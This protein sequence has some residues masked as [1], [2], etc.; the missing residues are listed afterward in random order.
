MPVVG[1][2]N[3]LQWQVLFPNTLVARQYTCEGVDLYVKS[4]RW[5]FTRYQTED[6]TL[7]SARNDKTTLPT[8]DCISRGTCRELDATVWLIPRCGQDISLNAG[9]GCATTAACLP[10][11]MAARSAGSGRDNLVLASARRWRQGL[12]V[13]GQDCAMSSATPESIGQSMGRTGTV[14]RAEGTRAGLLQGSGVAVH[15]FSYS[16]S[17]AC[18]RAPRMTSIVDKPKGERVAANVGLSGQPFAITGDTGM[19]MVDLGGG[20]V[21]VQVERLEGDE[22]DIF[23][24]NGIN[25]ELPAHPRALVPLQEAD[26]KDTEKLVVPYSYQTARIAAVNTRNYVFYASNPPM[27]VFGAYFEYC[28]GRDDRKRQIK[29][30]LLLKSSYSPIRIYRVSAYRRCAKYSCGNNLVSF[31]TLEGFS[32]NFTRSCDEVPLDDFALFHTDTHTSFIIS[33]SY[34]KLIPHLFIY[35]HRQT[36]SI[37]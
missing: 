25:Q 11:C 24:L 22:A 23:S 29:M 9:E 4:V 13:M 37:Y 36:T 5:S 2:M 7:G 30:G 32:Q 21:S 33:M 1:L 20:A 10:F 35:V 17:V 26:F 8:T 34:H 12:T 19:T 3:L 31:S 18:V 6:A 16:E 28:T 14:S 15:G 27:D